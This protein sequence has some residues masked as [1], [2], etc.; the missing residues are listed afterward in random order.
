MENEGKGEKQK[1][2]KNSNLD[3]VKRRHPQ[4]LDKRVQVVE[5]VVN[6]SARETPPADALEPADGFGSQTLVVADSVGLVQ[7]DPL[8]D[9]PLEEGA[10]EYIGIHHIITGWPPEKIIIRI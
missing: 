10:L 3:I 4:E 5:V 1:T 6:W 7:N 8:P 9:D 2:T